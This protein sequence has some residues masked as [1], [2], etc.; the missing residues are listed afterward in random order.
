[1]KI[2]TENALELFF[3]KTALSLV[4]FEAIANSLDAN[5]SNIDINIYMK[6]KTASHTLQITITDNGDGF[7]D[8]NFNRFDKLLNPK[9]E[10]H[11][12]IGRLVFLKYFDKIEIQSS[13]KNYRRTFI[14]NNK[15]IANNIV[16]ENLENNKI[17][18]LLFHNFKGSK[19][20][21]Y[22][23]IKPIELK[24]LIIQ[25]FLPRL[26]TLA[27]QE[28]PFEITINL[29]TGQAESNDI[30]EDKISITKNDLP[31]LIESEHPVIITS[32]LEKQYE[33]KLF[34]LVEKIDEISQLLIAFNIDNRTVV[35]ENFL[36]KSILPAKGYRCIFLFSSELFNNCA[37]TSRQKFNLPDEIS[38]NELNRRLRDAVGKI[39]T[40]KIPDIKDK[41]KKTK[42]EFEK[43][44][45][46]LIGYFEK[47]VVGL[48]DKDEALDDA[49][50]D[51]FKEQ[52]RI[53]SAENLTDEQYKKSI[54]FS[55]RALTEYVLYREKIIHKMSEL[56]NSSSSEAE[57]HNLIVPRYQL[58]EKKDLIS[59]AYQNNA[60]IL[61]DKFISFRTILSEKDMGEI[62][63]NI[64]LDNERITDR[65]RPDIALIF[66]ANPK[67][68][69]KVDVVIIEIKDKKDDLKDSMYA[70]NQLLNR[71][72]KLVKYCP[73]I[74]RMWYYAVMDIN[75][76]MARQLRQMGYTPLFSKG[77]VYYRE[78]MTEIYQ[79]G[80]EQKIIGQVPTPTI[81]MSFDAIIGDAKLR[82]H[83]FLQILR[84]SM[85]KLS[86]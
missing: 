41:N 31:K 56:L 20:H 25:H 30:Y 82:N 7:T 45:P 60:W 71:S 44:F 53:L 33:I 72:Y 51:F 16:S 14:F 32:N 84:E 73:N 11:K 36:K 85:K 18:R 83:T 34:Y 1:M 67:I 23:Y 59:S 40:D 66:S 86:R 81:I 37:D 19:I 38:L 15:G 46:H 70:I 29:Q 64:R 3:P 4:Y 8:E 52:K 42:Q 61:Y 26:N 77:Q 63:E 74:Q 22:D 75:H 17:T 28:I 65:G 55:S 79:D 10:S 54:E 68:D 39:L 50:A 24:K 62:I 35:A 49:Q 76:E 69:E 43:N 13:W 12:G 2:E 48:I 80:D 5:A 47:D 6:D 21:S 58:F 9:D 27:Q 57:I 78:N